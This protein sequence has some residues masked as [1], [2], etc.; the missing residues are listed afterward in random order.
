MPAPDPI[1]PR[2]RLIALVA[3][4]L[5]QLALGAAL[6]S[7]FRVDRLRDNELVSRLIEITLP[8]PPPLSRIVPP[9]IHRAERRAAAAPRTVPKPIGGSPGP[10]PSHALPIPTAAI[11]LHPSAPPSGG[12]TGSG[13]AAGSGAGGGS[14]GQG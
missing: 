3:A 8:P 14:G 2:E 6:L 11:P 1:R 7:G 5:L 13:P 4:A 9:R 10:P 12:G